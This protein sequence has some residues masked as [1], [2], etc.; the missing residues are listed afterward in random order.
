MS[1]MELMWLTGGA[2]VLLLIL[3]GFFSGSETALTATSRARM[4]LLSKSGDKRAEL[5]L[6]L[7]E[8]RD[9]LI[10]AILLGNNLVN[11]LSSALATSLFITLF[12]KA[13]VVYA[14]LVMTVLV[15]IFAEVLPKTYAI[16]HADKAALKVARPIRAVILIFSPVTHAVQ[17]IVRG[18]LKLFGVEIATSLDP[19]HHEEELRG[20][21]DLHNGEDVDTKEERA[22]L[23]SILDLDDVPVEDIMTHRSKVAMLD[24]N[25]PVTETVEAVMQSSYTRLPVYRDNIDNIVGVVHAKALLR[26]LRAKPD[27][28]EELDLAEIAANPWFIPDT[29]TLLDQLRAFRERREHFAIVVDE[30]GDFLGIVTLED[31]LEEIVGNIDDETD[32]AVPGVRPQG[33]GTY[34]VDGSVTLRTLARELEWDLPDEHA[35]TIAGYVLHEARL[36]PDPGQVFTFNGFRFEVLRRQRNQIT[37]LKVTPATDDEGSDSAGVEAPA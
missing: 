20:A 35:A 27:A 30:Y 11:I 3:S 33:D 14:T 10:G 32:V 5:V 16:S 28:L 8:S 15:L 22:M 34:L 17:L 1:E 36:I 7:L 25:Q 37:A 6:L 4:H 23:R 31:I 2:I 18:T 26:A 12:G 29:T 24:L 21:I 13:G 9:K 19:E